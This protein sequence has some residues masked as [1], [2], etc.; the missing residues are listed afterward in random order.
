MDVENS[1]SVMFEFLG[2]IIAAC[3][4]RDS[5][6]RVHFKVCLSKLKC[7]FLVQTRKRDFCTVSHFDIEI[8]V[9]WCIILYGL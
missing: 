1:W 9:N 3:K 4:A 2:A 5:D 8:R 7:I 6:L